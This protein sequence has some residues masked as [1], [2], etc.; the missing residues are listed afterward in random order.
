MVRRQSKTVKVMTGKDVEPTTQKKRGKRGGGG[1]REGR[2]GRAAVA[3]ASEGQRGNRKKRRLT[4]HVRH[5]NNDTQQSLRRRNDTPHKIRD[6]A[7]NNGNHFFFKP[8][9]GGEGRRMEC[10]LLSG[11]TCHSTPEKEREREREA[12]HTVHN[13]TPH[14]RTDKEG[15]PNKLTNSRGRTEGTPRKRALTLCAQFT[16]ECTRTCTH[17]RI[18]GIDSHRG[19]HW[20]RR[21]IDRVSADDEHKTCVPVLPPHTQRMGQLKK[22]NKKQ[23]RHPLERAHTHAT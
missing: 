17:E 21:D 15:E 19:H 14:L 16:F 8:P 9:G 6:A 11:P 10:W 13:M 22:R 12:R 7:N 18:R 23:Y 4:E 3:R 5:T 20:Q 2:R 1:G